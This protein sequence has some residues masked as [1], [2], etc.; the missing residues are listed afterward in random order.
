MS[1]FAD[2]IE[3]RTHLAGLLQP[4]LGEW[5][6][7]SPRIHIVPPRQKKTSRTK[8]TATTDSELECIIER[9]P[10]GQPFNISGPQK[11]QEP[12]Y[13]VRLVNFADDTKLA[14]AL[15]VIDADSRIIQDRPK[16]YQS[17][18]DIA[19]E[20]ASIFVRTAKIINSVVY[21]A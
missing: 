5:E 21:S 1:T 9:V 13:T 16:I 19:Y 18:D 11:Y 15:P 4:Y 14:N 3:L 12:V 20:Q 17:G 6:S 2:A 7:G 8:A 10:S